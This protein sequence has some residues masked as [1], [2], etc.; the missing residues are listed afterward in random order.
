MYVVHRTSY[1]RLLGRAPGKGV[2]T[3]AFCD[4]NGIAFS[5]ENGVCLEGSSGIALG[6]RCRGVDAG[7]QNDFRSI[8]DARIRCRANTIFCFRLGTT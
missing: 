3:S 1:R 8:L 5:F 4:E 2:S 6:P 7:F